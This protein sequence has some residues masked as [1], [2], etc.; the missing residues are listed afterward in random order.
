MVIRHLANGSIFELNTLSSQILRG[1]VGAYVGLTE[2][3]H[4]DGTFTFDVR[5]WRLSS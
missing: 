5:S 4:Q 2:T 3:G 1:R